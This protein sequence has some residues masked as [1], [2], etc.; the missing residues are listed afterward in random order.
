MLLVIWAAS[1]GLDEQGLP[2]DNHEDI[3]IVGH[4][5]DND[6]V[7]PWNPRETSQDVRWRERKDKIDAMLREVLELIDFHGVMRRPSFDGVQALLLALPLLEGNN[8]STV[9][10]SVPPHLLSTDA[11]P[12]EKIAIHEATLSQV[13]ALCNPGHRSLGQTSFSNDPDDGLIRARIFWYAHTHEGLVTG[14]KG[15]RFVL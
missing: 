2:P 3:G 9:N 11:P 6:S 12:L 7:D 13:R 15:G 4:P 10:Y 5:L 8:L 1:F 14:M